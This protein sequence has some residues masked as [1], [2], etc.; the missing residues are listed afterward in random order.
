MRV[1]GMLLV[2]L[3]ILALAVPSFTFF[4]T[5]RA[6]DAGFFTIDYEKPHTI[7]LNPIVGIVAVLAGVL[8]LFTSR[9]TEAV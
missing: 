4:T 1:F 5:E 6:V 9:R 8:I 3:G 7:V 2:V